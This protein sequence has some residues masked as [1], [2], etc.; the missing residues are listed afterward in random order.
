MIARFPAVW[1]TAFFLA[2]AGLDLQ[3]QGGD[4]G[5]L[6]SLKPPPGS[7]AANPS[8]ET[9]TNPGTVPDP[10][11]P[12]SQLPPLMPPPPV[13]ENQRDPESAF[14]PGSVASLFPPLDSSGLPPLQ[15]P[16]EPGSETDLPP[17]LAASKLKWRRNPYGARE[18]AAREDRFLLVVFGGW[19]WDRLSEALSWELF[20]TEEFSR[21][22]DEHLVLSFVEFPRKMHTAHEKVIA[23]KEAYQIRGNPTVILFDADGMPFFRETGYRKGTARSYLEKL[24]EAVAEQR[25]VRHARRQ[26]LIQRGFRLWTGVKGQKMFAKLVGKDDQDRLRFIDPQGR[27]YGITPENLDEVDRALVPYLLSK[28]QGAG[29]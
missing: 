18:Q 17:G 6:P 8:V 27:P 23:F 13:P 9:P 15:P 22:S 3:A 20:A 19:E 28:T 25:E 24:Q 26:E 16:P 5:T 7:A 14:A 11:N 10:A 29:K 21:Y 4:P 2:G 1:T 12:A